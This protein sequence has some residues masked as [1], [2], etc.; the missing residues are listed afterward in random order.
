MAAG[1]ALQEHRQPGLGIDPQLALVAGGLGLVALRLGELA[2]VA[3]LRIVGA[4]DEGAELAGLQRQPA[5]PTGGA[6]ARVGPVAAIGEDVRAQRLVERL[7]HL[8]HAQVADL[9]HRAGEVGPELPQQHLPVE[10]PGR[11]QVELLFQGGGEVVLHVLEE[12]LL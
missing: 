1:G 3:A 7:Q 10:L 4:A 2:G 8:A 6:A 9:A 11:D 5:G 12:E